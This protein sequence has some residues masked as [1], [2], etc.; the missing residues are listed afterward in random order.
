MKHYFAKSY[1]P[2][3]HSVDDK[4]LNIKT[5]FDPSKS[6]FRCHATESSL[7]N[8]SLALNATMSTF[9]HTNNNDK[10]RFVNKNYFILKKRDSSVLSTKICH[11][12]NKSL[13]NNAL[14]QSHD[15]FLH[16]HNNSFNKNTGLFNKNSKRN[17]INIDEINFIETLPN[18]YSKTSH[19]IEESEYIEHFDK[20]IDQSQ[21]NP[22]LVIEK[23]NLK[24]SRNRENL[25]SGQNIFNL[26]QNTQQ[27]NRRV[28]PEKKRKLNKLQKM[29]DKIVL[30]MEEILY[31]FT[32]ELD[33]NKAQKMK[34]FKY[35][36]FLDKGQFVSEIYFTKN[37]KIITQLREILQNQYDY[38]KGSQINMGFY[39]SCISKLSNLCKGT[40][41]GRFNIIIHILQAKLYSI[42]YQFSKAIYTVHKALVISYTLED[43]EMV[44][45]SYKV[46]GDINNRL[47]NPNV[48]MNFYTKYLMYA[49]ILNNKSAEI[50]GYDFLG[51]QYFHLDQIDKSNSFHNKMMEGDIEKRDSDVKK[52]ARQ[53]IKKLEERINFVLKIDPKFAK[54]NKYISFVNLLTEAFKP[55]LFEI[56]K[57]ELEQRPLNK[58]SDGPDLHDL[59]NA[60]EDDENEYRSFHD[61]IMNAE[62]KNKNLKNNERIS[63]LNSSVDRKRIQD[64]ILK[65]KNNKLN[66]LAPKIM[67][68]YTDFGKLLNQN[69]N[70]A[71][72]YEFSAQNRMNK[73]EMKK[74]ILRSHMSH[75]KNVLN[76]VLNQ[77]NL[78]A[79]K[80]S[81]IEFNNYKCKQ[82]MLKILDKYITV[83]DFMI[84][85][86]EKIMLDHE[87]N[88]Y[89]SLYEISL[90]KKNNFQT[91]I[92]TNT[93]IHENLNSSLDLINNPND[94]HDYK[95]SY[96]M[97]VPGKR[98]PYSASKNRF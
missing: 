20:V 67:V 36:E 35:F 8:K 9:R 57:D 77:P 32:Y 30:S 87:R 28:N 17:D 58:K 60:I 3:T 61:I 69:K 12:K 19:K 6:L 91:K 66:N 48:A 46:L 2:T 86:L 59:D 26:N 93:L 70:C 64:H 65:E 52:N 97:Y 71:A 45:K 40:L 98:A 33:I 62:R 76:F 79:G 72:N 53:N 24:Y 18:N 49:L 11:R 41:I 85:S 29:A 27:S 44:L 83:F 92:S 7:N 16:T 50:S 90:K 51:L 95:S 68:K 31:D 15:S 81:D 75:N 38:L 5:P 4:K 21:N 23:S 47:N 78:I 25:R 54:I 88:N 96:K 84:E 1:R 80:N 37:L 74:V 55:Q 43:K 14:Q 89:K 94:M 22:E 34:E 39:Q 56:N 42:I 13:G 63:S 73:T 10:E 82:N